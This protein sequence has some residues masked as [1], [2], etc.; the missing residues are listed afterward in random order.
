MLFTL[1]VNSTFPPVSGTDV[2]LAVLITLILN[3]ELIKVQVIVS[4]FAKFKAEG[5]CVFPAMELV[6]EE[7]ECQPVGTVSVTE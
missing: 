5:S 2:G 1:A 6:Q 7:A 3:F 4:P